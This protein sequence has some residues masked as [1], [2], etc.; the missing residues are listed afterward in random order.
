MPQSDAESL[1]GKALSP[2]QDC[3][4]EEEATV[5]WRRSSHVIHNNF[6]TEERCACPGQTQVDLPSVSGTSNDVHEKTA[7]QVSIYTK[8]LSI[9]TIITVTRITN[10]R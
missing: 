3:A 8:L 5:G 10:F 9:T 2:S 4:R 6:G 1:D 7:K